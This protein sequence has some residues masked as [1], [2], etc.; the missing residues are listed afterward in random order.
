MLAS[1]WSVLALLFAVR[2]GMGIQFQ[3]VGALSPLWM[4]DLSAGIAEIGLLIG[5]YHAPG[6][7][8]ALPGGAIGQRLG[9]KLGAA[10]GLA[11][12]IAGGALAALASDW[13]LQVAARLLAGIGGILLNVLVSKMVADWFAGKEIDTAMAIIGNASPVGIA[14][15][16]VAL[17]PI[18]AAGG[19]VPTSWAVVACLVA[20]LVALAILYRA[21]PHVPK[22]AA[23]RRSIWPG[24]RAM[25]AVLAA[26]LVYGIYNAGI[27]AVFTFA[28]L[29]LME[30]G[31]PMAE[32]GSSTSLFLW[33]FA[34]SVPAGGVLADRTGRSTAIL[35]GGLA[36]FAVGLVLTPRIDAP[37]TLLVVLGI[38]SGLPCGPIMS[39][40]ARALEPETR[41]VGIGICFTVYYL[42]QVAAPW[43]FG[44]A[45][46]IGGGPRMAFDMAAAS[47]C[48]GGLAWVFYRRLVDGPAI[49]PTSVPPR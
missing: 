6:V 43:F 25:W 4:S 21:P 1:R 45:A 7:A 13:S 2:T 30:R 22:S 41:S 27:V 12:M 31:W 11:L 46:E 14:L 37:I 26:G 8:M 36:C 24:G 9:E 19:L 10:I 39:L 5:L 35:L 29:M 48:V 32:A 28:P 49:R 23:R 18:A 40:A 16:L 17:P 34:L 20:A 33:L 15:A 3:A 44:R 47:L 38:A 42:V